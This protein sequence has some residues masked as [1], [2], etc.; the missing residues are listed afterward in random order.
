VAKDRAEAADVRGAAVEAIPS[1]EGL[2]ATPLLT[3]LAKDSTDNDHVR[4]CAAMSI[5]KLTD[6]AIDDVG[7]LPA[8]DGRY[9]TEYSKTALVEAGMATK[10]ALKRIAEHGKTE[11]VR[12][13][14]KVMFEKYGGAKADILNGT[15]EEK[16]K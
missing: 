13:T 5:V 16:G 9:A 4:C 15:G 12:A 7:I 3:C 14:A 10:R 1:I 11:A 8:F 6:G 2:R